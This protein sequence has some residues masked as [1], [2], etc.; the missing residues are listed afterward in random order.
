MASP[1]LSEKISVIASFLSNDPER[2]IDGSSS[3]ESPGTFT[4]FRRNIFG[5][6]LRRPATCER[7]Y[8]S[9]LVSGVRPSDTSHRSSL[10]CLPRSRLTGVHDLALALS[11]SERRD[12]AARGRVPDG[13]CAHF[14]APQQPDP[15]LRPEGFARAAALR[16]LGVQT[17]ATRLE[18]SYSAGTTM[19]IPAGRAHCRCQRVRHKI[20]NNGV[21]IGHARLERQLSS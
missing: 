18:R 15:H 1:A 2:G 16:R 7:P 20:G 19:Q 8:L 6:R 9:R 12:H 13:G 3:A 10:S 17:A 21:T 5:L 11:C 4:T 14:F